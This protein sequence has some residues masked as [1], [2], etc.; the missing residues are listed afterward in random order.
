MARP[1]RKKK[2][3]EDAAIMLF[4][5]KGLARTV[6]KDIAREAGV[7]EGAL[8][9][10]YR[11]KDEMA[12]TL[13]SREL[14]EFAT[15][16][17]QYMFVEKL[18]IKE[19]VYNLVKYIFQYYKDHPIKFKFII[20]TQH[21]FP[22]EDLLNEQYNPNDMITSFIK[23]LVDVKL[24]SAVNPVLMGGMLMGLVLQPIV[25]HGY[26]R[27]EKDPVEYGDTIAEACLK[28]MGI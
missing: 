21:G 18:T 2:D 16:L 1:L 14:K 20:L 26:G 9:R 22:E 25:M 11:S 24:I 19:R 28:V 8:Y 10:H 6:I 15:G 27:L 17:E 23:S 5:T 3:I 7:T 4:A 12:W 13:F